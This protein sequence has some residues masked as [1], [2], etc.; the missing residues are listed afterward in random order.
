MAATGLAGFA[1][2]SL[3]SELI[4]GPNM[5]YLALIAVG[6]GRRAGLAAVGGV[7]AGLAGLGLAAALGLAALVEA[8]PV[9]YQVLRWGGI[10][11]LLWLAWLAWRGEE[12][13]EARAAAGA[14]PWRH[15]RRGLITNLLNPKAAVFYVAVQPAFLPAEPG[16]ADIVLF[17]ATF[18]AIATGVHAGVVVL[19]GAVHGLLARPSRAA[20]L[21][22]ASAAGLV[23]VA[24]WVAATT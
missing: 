3:L 18:V 23:A 15:F 5:G 19:A 1:L 13:A 24:A 11:W 22:R 12:G 8:S 7:A 20:A 10:A 2:A 9:A 14:P 16:T 6:E 17:S 4:P 21:R